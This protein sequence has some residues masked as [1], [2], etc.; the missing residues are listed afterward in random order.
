MATKSCSEYVDSSEASSVEQIRA[1]VESARNTI[2]LDFDGVLH[3][4]RNGWTGHVPEEPP[5]PGAL[6][7]VQYLLLRGWT[8]VVYSARAKQQEGADGI[9]RWL[10]QHGFPPLHVAVG[11]PTASAYVDDRAV[12]FDGD[13]DLIA[14]Q[15]SH[16]ERFRS[17]VENLCEQI[18]YT[19]CRKG[20]RTDFRIP[21]RR[22]FPTRGT[23]I[24]DAST[25][26]AP[27][28]EFEVALLVE[29]DFESIAHRIAKRT[30]PSSITLH[31]MIN[32]GRHDDEVVDLHLREE[33]DFQ[34]HAEFFDDVRA[35]ALRLLRRTH[36]RPQV[37]EVCYVTAHAVPTT[38]ETK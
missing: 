29:P 27:G 33:V 24:A 18:E 37:R 8:V 1:N 9:C 19:W 10:D 4:Y 30:C 15:L 16:P 13:F 25:A 21:S 23:A 11:K 38:E 5:V 28:E 22:G 20:H 34:D 17:W 35:A 36:S 3:Q 6:E 2:A 12:R 31:T 14:R 7:F 26:L 32:A